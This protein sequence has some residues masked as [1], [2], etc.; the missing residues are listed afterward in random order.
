MTTRG[1]PL[2]QSDHGL[3]KTI[4]IVEGSIVSATLTVAYFA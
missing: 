2:I 3:V 4:M 1:L